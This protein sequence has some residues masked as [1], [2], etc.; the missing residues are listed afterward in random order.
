MNNPALKGEVS[1][2][3]KML[4]Q[5]NPR[6]RRTDV[7]FNSFASCVTN[8]SEELSW[9]PEMSFSEMPSQPRMLTEEFKGRIAFEQLKCF[10]G[11]H[12]CW[13]L[14]EE[15]H[16]IDS[17]V[18]LVNPESMSLSSFS[19]KHFDVNSDPI[20]SHRVFGV[21]GLPNKVEIIL[22]ESVSGTSQIPFFAPAKL[23]GDKAHANIAKFNSRG[24]TA[25][26][27][28]NQFNKLNFEDGNSSLGF[29][30]RGILAVM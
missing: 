16:M 26:L 4:S 12:G 14:N 20:K 1:T 28:S 25:P 8:T 21:L 5:T 13:H 17:N 19:D 18:Q 23:A 29:Q 10:T 6:L 24:A 2:K 3:E 22:P 27:V 11:A 7:M 15:M 30:S 9:T